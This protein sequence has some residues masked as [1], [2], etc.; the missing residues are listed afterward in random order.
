MK[1]LR[2]L[3][4]DSVHP[5]ESLTVL[6]K[7]AGPS[8]AAMSYEEYYGWLMEQRLNLSDYLTKPMRE[9]GWDARE[10]VPVDTLLMDKFER[11]AGAAGRG[12]R[13]IARF[14]AS[15][16]PRDLTGGRVGRM[17]REAKRRNQVAGC[18]EGFK[19]DVLFVREPC[20]VDG[21]VFDAFRDRCLVVGMIACDPAHA[22]HWNAHR[23]DVIFTATP[24]FRD[25][26]RSLGIRSEILPFGVDERVATQVE[27]LPKIYDCTFVG[28]LGAPHQRQKTE[29]LERVSGAADFKWWGVKGPEIAQFPA[30]MRT[31]Q[32]EAAGLEMLKIYKQSRIVLNDYPDFMQGH[33][34]N[35]RNMEVFSVGSFLL[36]R[37]AE[38]LR[39]LEA[40][41]ALVTF[42][43]ADDCIAK[44]R[45]CLDHEAERE[46]VALKGRALALQKFNYRD[47]ARRVM[48]V[49][50]E[51]YEKK[52]KRR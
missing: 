2:L 45:Y 26:F 18:I 19:P 17:W 41:G 28:Y 47:I 30:L 36:T 9:E 35:M 4:I 29:L 13:D 14:V 39:P 3:K 6:Q 27:G 32:G 1:Q 21:R 43:D 20:H 50:G 7:S 52:T 10:L 33:S 48:D 51:E 8:L 42:S 34:N 16:A 5:P 22:V 23:H 44:V 24:E 31:W 25:Y 12:M 37:A 15:V 40:E 38:A 46:A 11:F 49:I